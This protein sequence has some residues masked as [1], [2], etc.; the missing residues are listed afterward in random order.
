MFFQTCACCPKKVM[1]FL[2]VTT[3]Q[4]YSRVGGNILVYK[5]YSRLFTGLQIVKQLKITVIQLF[6]S[7]V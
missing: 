4:G 6:Y 7:K 5:G 3:I 1:A 2:F